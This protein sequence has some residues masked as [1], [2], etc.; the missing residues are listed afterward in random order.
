[1][2]RHTEY[3]KEAIERSEE[4]FGTTTFLHIAKEIAYSHHEKWDGSGYPLGLSGERIPVAG[5]LMALADVYDALISQRVYKP[6]FP[7]RR[8]VEMIVAEHG[9]HFDPSVCDAFV[10]LEEEFRVISRRYAD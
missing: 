6:A 1:M 2:K 9:R 4:N 5:R 8:A 10:S 3:G 7:H